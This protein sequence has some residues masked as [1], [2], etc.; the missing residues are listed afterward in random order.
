M[1]QD[2]VQFIVDLHHLHHLQLIK[3]VKV[4]HGA[5]SLFEDNAEFGYG[6][7]LAQNYNEAHMI[8]VM[9][10]A[11]DA[12]EPELKETIEKYLSVKGSKKRRKSNCSR[13]IKIS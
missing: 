4:Q 6:M 2:V 11:K 5:N 3:M 1:L 12:C 9:E 13:I 10:N 7:K 8:Q